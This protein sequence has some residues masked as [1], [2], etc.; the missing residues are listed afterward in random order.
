MTRI[1]P[2]NENDRA[3]MLETAEREAIINA[4]VNR[5]QESPLIIEGIRV[6]KDC[7]GD[8]AAAR[9]AAMPNSV[10]CIECQTIFDN[11]QQHRL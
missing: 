11:Q 8:I 7:E 3:T 4:H 10:R 9:L 2:A 5:P 1:F 6:C